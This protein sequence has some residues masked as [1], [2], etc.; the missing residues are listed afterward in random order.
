MTARWPLVVFYN[1]LDIS[2]YNSFV[3]WSEIK[4]AWNQGK[5]NRRRLFMEELGQQLT[6]NDARSALSYIFVALP[7]VV[8]SQFE[9]FVFAL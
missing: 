2:A 3:L 4:P 1:I 6:S 9:L 5:Y 7:S 8:T